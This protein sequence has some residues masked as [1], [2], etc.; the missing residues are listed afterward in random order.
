M[1]KS[2]RSKS[3]NYNKSLKQSKKR[4]RGLVGR[5]DRDRR[6]PVGRGRLGGGPSAHPPDKPTPT[7][8]PEPQSAPGSPDERS[9]REIV[10]TF[11][12]D[13]LEL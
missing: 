6:P 11:K 2:R 8:T 10:S 3:V 5:K 1:A 9:L 12:P 7:A 13:E 4:A